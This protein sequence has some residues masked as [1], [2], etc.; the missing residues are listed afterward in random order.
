MAVLDQV[1]AQGLVF[2]MNTCKHYSFFES[3]A[4]VRMLIIVRL[5]AEGLYRT[6][7]LLELSVNNNSAVGRSSRTS[8]DGEKSSGAGAPS[9]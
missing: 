1:R 9:S 8:S 4:R 6:W 5:N 3:M 7:S 2:H